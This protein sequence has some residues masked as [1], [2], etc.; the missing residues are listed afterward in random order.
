VISISEETGQIMSDHVRAES[1]S[2]A[3]SV[4]AGDR[5]DVT[6]VAVLDGHIFEGAGI[7]FP[8]D[9]MVDA[10]TVLGQ[11]EVFN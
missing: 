8:G 6:F 5:L 2:Q 7:A 9:R 11:P 4:V 3:F 10:E 1:G